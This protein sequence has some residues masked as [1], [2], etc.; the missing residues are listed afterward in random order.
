MTTLISF[1]GKGRDNTQTGYRTATYRFD[2]NFVYTVPFF[3]IALTKYI[4]P[5]R[6][7]LIGTAA[8]MWD[9]FF[10]HQ[11]GVND[12]L[13]ALTD[14]VASNKVS[15]DMLK[16]FATGVSR[17]LG[18][19]VQC[20]L[21]PFARN[22][23]EQI[24]ILQRL[25]GCVHRNEKVAI[26]I[27]HGFR[28]Q[29][30]L[31]LVAARY[32]ARIA[33]VTV[34]EIF[35]GALEMSMN[36]EAPVLKLSGM[37]QMLDWVDALATYDKDGDYGAFASLLIHD[38]MDKSRADL[39]GRAAF[40][41]R[42]NNPVKAREALSSVAPDIDAHPGAYA[43]LFKDELQRRI[44]WAKKGMRH[45]WELALGSNY[46][47]RHDYLRAA[48]FMQEAFVTRTIYLDR[49]DPNDFGVRKDTVDA[50]RDKNK[51]FKALVY[52]RNALAHGVKPQNEAIAKL[53]QDEIS[54]RDE[55]LRLRKTLF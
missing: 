8:S 3:G 53:L 5:D 29:P 33:N 38:G 21:I 26:D 46:L 44:G 51:D 52:L 45:D 23:H 32:L 28:H 36:G 15:E 2:A 54:L 14:A 41:E 31:A 25:A 20:V 40:F 37:L 35:Y 47:D 9:V 17:Q 22:D 34:E 50:C 10:E 43:A 19:D 18:V 24:G 1:L 16:D 4:K 39:L 42:T 7:I 11:A 48:V 30:M 12:Q 55:I 49:G 13:L 27:T 6:L